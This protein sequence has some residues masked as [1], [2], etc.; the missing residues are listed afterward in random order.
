MYIYTYSFMISFNSVYSVTKTTIF[1]IEHLI[2]QF[3]SLYL[4]QPTYPIY[5]KQLSHPDS[6]VRSMLS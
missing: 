5:Y 2:Y 6:T 3:G 4:L 1:H